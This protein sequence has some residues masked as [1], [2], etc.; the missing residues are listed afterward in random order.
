MVRMQVQLT[1]EQIRALRAIA[2]RE[3]VS[4]SELVRR[5]VDAIVSGAPANAGASRSKAL[6]II[7]GFR[8]GVGDLATRHDDYLGDAL[9]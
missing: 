9:G 7:G 4:L 5:G 6:A 3:G 1:E 8:S 2:A